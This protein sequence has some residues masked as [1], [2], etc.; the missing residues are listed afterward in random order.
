MID[1]HLP[2]EVQ[3]EGSSRVSVEITFGMIESIKRFI[4]EEDVKALMSLGDALKHAFNDRVGEVHPQYKQQC[5]NI[6]VLN[7]SALSSKRFG[8]GAIKTFGASLAPWLEQRLSWNG[9]CSC[10]SL[11]TISMKTDCGPDSCL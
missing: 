4:T 7:D 10:R 5:D 1:D 6:E 9:Q 8:I 3:K 2:H 11:E